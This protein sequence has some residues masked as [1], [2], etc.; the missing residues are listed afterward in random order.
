[1]TDEKPGFGQAPSDLGAGTAWPLIARET[2]AR[3]VQLLRDNLEGRA[4]DSL[5]KDGPDILARRRHGEP[6]LAVELKVWRWSRRN[7][8][9]RISEALANAVRH[10]R[11]FPGGVHLGFVAAVLLEPDAGLS[12]MTD[13]VDQGTVLSRLLRQSP[14]DAGF[15]RVVFCVGDDDAEWVEVDRAGN[16]VRLADVADA[17]AH[18]EASR[19]DLGYPPTA[20]EPDPDRPPRVL[21]VADEWRSRSGGISTFN[22]EFA[23]AFADAGCDVHVLVPTAD[24][25]ERDEA[26]A[27]GVTLVTPDPIPG[28]ADKALL[29]TRPRFEV[30]EY[31]P[32]LIVGHGR[33]L[34]PYAYAVKNLLFP[35]AK[36]LHIVHTDAERLEMI[37]EQQDGRS[38]IAAA[39]E[40]TAL[41]VELALSA[42]LVAGIGPLLT[43][44]IKD[45]MRGYEQEAPAVIEIL[46]G[47]RD[48]GG[49]INDPPA[50]RQVLL[51][52]RAEDIRSKGIDIA[53]RAVA[54]ALGK[55]ES[56]T[57]DTPTLVVRGVPEDQA[58]DIKERLDRIVAPDW[59]VVPRTYT[60]DMESLK[61]DLWQSRVLV[62]PS[63]HEGFGLV[64]LE[65]IAAGVPVLV[66]RESGLGRALRATV[67]DAER[68][69]PREVLAAGGADEDVIAAWGEAIYE[70]LVDPEAAFARAA[71][72]RRQIE[73]EMS[74]PRAVAAVLDGLGMAVPEPCPAPAPDRIRSACPLGSRVSTSPSKGSATCCGTASLAFLLTSALMLG[75]RNRS[76]PSGG[77]SGARSI[78]SSR[79]ISSARSYSLLA[80]GRMRPSST[81]S[82]ALQ[83]PPCFSQR[84]ETSSYAKATP[85]VP[86]L[87]KASMS[88]DES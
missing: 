64:A 6:L 54:Y 22:R 3:F 78:P 56:D 1:M 12:A 31:Q 71:D 74:W 48:W 68:Q 67:K 85:I 84:C 30:P 65:A 63:R 37:K 61:R 9:N 4:L 27:T 87:S 41:E 73:T 62:M 80:A 81:V 17:L 34:G 15:E 57:G 25:E 45:D 26:L 38:A 43:E 72:I 51:I 39:E 8:N 28:V 35:S 21:F 50:R 32:E 2:E 11:E 59:V 77:I 83:Q 75:T 55:F 82:S 76:T 5:R 36:R 19:S 42:D 86:R 66:S 13:F 46:P 10:R 40:R 79:S 16:L 14:E 47:L 58:D 44:R 24:G 53:A 52:A 18:L 23:T 69:E 88:P 60:P 7:L 70:R 33:I 20:P 49:M 29:L